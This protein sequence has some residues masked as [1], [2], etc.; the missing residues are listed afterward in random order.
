MDLIQLIPYRGQGVSP[1]VFETV[2]GDGDLAVF[3]I[4]FDQSDVLTNFST[5]PVRQTRPSSIFWF[6]RTMKRV[7]TLEGRTG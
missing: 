5:T 4:G 1:R 6:M 3:N 2:N 7:M